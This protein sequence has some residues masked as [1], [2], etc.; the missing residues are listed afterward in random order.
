MNSLCL[1]RKTLP[2]VREM[3]IDLYI[4]AELI[5][6]IY[7]GDNYSFKK[8]SKAKMSNCLIKH[9]ITKSECIAPCILTL[10]VRWK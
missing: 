9:C 5:Y 6:V 8:V 4:S 7:F 2:K 10:F 1:L 3:R